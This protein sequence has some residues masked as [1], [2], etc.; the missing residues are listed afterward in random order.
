[1][2][3]TKRFS[4][5]RCSQFCKK[6]YMVEM[7]KVYRKSAKKYKIPYHS[8]KQDKQF[9]YTTCKKTFCN[10]PCDGYNQ[11][12]KIKH[13]FTTSYSK[14]RINMFKQKGALSGCVDVVDYNVFHK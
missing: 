10:K 8:T 6:D 13:G 11:P 5:N 9:A 3:K 2:N 4:K 12:L 7:D 14:H 1:M